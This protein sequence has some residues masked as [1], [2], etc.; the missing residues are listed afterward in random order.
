MVEK[1][2][3]PDPFDI[4]IYAVIVRR[5]TWFRKSVKLAAASKCISVVLKEFTD[6]SIR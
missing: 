1:D 5:T 2:C 4:F 3:L 6:V